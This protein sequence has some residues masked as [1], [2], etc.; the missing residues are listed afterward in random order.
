MDP[1]VKYDDMKVNPP[2]VYLWS[3]YEGFLTNGCQ[4]NYELMKNLHIKDDRR[5]TGA[6]TV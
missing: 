6:G 4:D 3:K 1:R 5:G 2:G